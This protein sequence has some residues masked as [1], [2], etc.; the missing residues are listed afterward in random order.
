MFPRPQN[1]E[2]SSDRHRVHTMRQ[3]VEEGRT[4]SG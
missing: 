3:N 4:E 1:D 2:E